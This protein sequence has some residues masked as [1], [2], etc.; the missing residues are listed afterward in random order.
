ML[1]MNDCAIDP[2]DILFVVT[3][4]K[5]PLALFKQA[6][7]SLTTS[8]SKHGHREVISVF[9]CTEKNKYGV[10][11]HNFE[12][13]LSLSPESFIKTLQEKTVE[14]LSV[15][16]LN[17]CTK[18][19]TATRIKEA[20]AAG[21]RW[22]KRLAKN[23]KGTEDTEELIKQFLSASKENKN[24][25]I[26]LLVTF[27]RAS[28][29]AEIL[30]MVNSSLLLFKHTDG[31]T[32]QQ[33]LDAYLEQVK[34]TE[35][36][37]AQGKARTS[38]WVLIKSFFKG[39]NQ[40]KKDRE[41]NPP[42]EA[43]YC[44]RNLMQVLNQVD[45]NLVDR[46]R[47]VLPKALEAGFREATKR[48]IQ[49]ESAVNQQQFDDFENMIAAQEQL[50]PPF[51]LQIL[52]ASGRKLMSTLLAVVDDEIRRIETKWWANEADKK[53][54]S[55]LKKLLLPFRDPKLQAYPV[56]L[57][58][59]IG[60]ELIATLLPTLQRKTGLL[61]EWFPATSYSHVR[62]F[63]RTQG[64]FD[65]DIREAIEKL[66]SKPSIIEEK[67]T[68]EEELENSKT[69]SKS[70]I[71]IFADWS[72]SSWSTSKRELLLEHMIGLLAAG[73][74]LYTWENRQLVK[75]NKESLQKAINGEN[76]DDLLA[77]KLMPA[78]R[79]TLS[80]QAEQQKLD[81]TKVHFLDYKACQN[82]VNDR[83]S[84]A[85][86]LN[87]VAPLFAT[88]L[89]DYH[90]G[91]AKQDIIDIEIANVENHEIERVELQQLK[92]QIA[93][94]KNVKQKNYQSGIDTKAFVA[95]PQY[96][97]PVFKP[98]DL[99]TLTPSSKYY[100]NEV[101]SDL[102]V[103]EAPS[104]P[105]QYFELLGMN[106]TENPVH[107]KYKFHSKG[108]TNTLIKKRKEESTLTLFE[109]EKNVCLTRDWQALP[110]L[111]PNETLVDVAIKGLKKDD[112]E[113]K[114]SQENHLYYIR[115][116]KSKAVPIDATIN[117]LLRMPKHYR[118]NPIFNTLTKNPEH[119]EIHHLLMKYLKF[120]K[121][122]GK[123]RDSIGVTIH[124]GH[125]YLNEA[126]KLSIG[127]CRLR[128]IA[129]KEEMKRV[130]PEVPVSVVVNSD[131]CFIEMKLDGLWQ[132]YCLG[133][134]RDTPS[135]I[136]SV[137]EDTLTS[138]RSDSRKNRFFTEKTIKSQIN[139]PVEQAAM[140]NSI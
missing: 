12:R 67:H 29:Q 76:F 31:K 104:S 118:S 127:S 11:C 1:V 97:K 98:V 100:R 85:M 30:P 27:W 106:A 134:Y 26:Q 44:S 57:Q 39:S 9:V 132:R 129:F 21:P 111:D 125:E 20:L 34:L 128:A 92:E 102:T 49:V 109:G 69:S 110:S 62:A 3:N 33:F 14:E 124:N 71:Y 46:G 75:M 93:A 38:L 72:F 42:S 19:F 54:A 140:V 5:K 80:Q 51:T 4:S 113:I 77:S 15:L 99:I 120:G 108:I 81:T 66:K 6:A 56:N 18:E 136:E 82:L 137:K 73:H 114:Y 43:T 117:L 90:L 53:K 105:F 65:G 64:I 101:Y 115:L 79:T 50:L 68:Q 2:G 88:K 78:T 61:G 36:L 52:P 126:R 123:L 131:H 133:G 96:R 121:D 25:L 23:M 94:Q 55:D 8:R 87:N 16:L 45:P 138:I 122:H 22:M 89:D 17:Y 40:D 83:E 35:K 139:V 10:I 107:C 58:V 28:G 95:Q 32:R 84:L 74:S 24:R 112:F 70:Q 60:L 86:K 91:Q 116:T 119:Q 48:K 7:Q 135:F 41:K 130:H 47:H 59:D 13:K 63:A 103:N 37:H